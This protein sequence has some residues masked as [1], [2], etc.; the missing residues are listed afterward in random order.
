MIFVLQETELLSGKLGDKESSTDNADCT[1][2]SDGWRDKGV[3]RKLRT[4]LY[5]S[6]EDSSFLD[7]NSFHENVVQHC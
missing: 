3:F 6:I 1:C 4:R 5:L 2:R 7:N